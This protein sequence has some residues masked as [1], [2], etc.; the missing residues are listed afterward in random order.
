M[1]KR[2]IPVLFAFVFLLPIN[3]SAY[4]QEGS[5]STEIGYQSSTIATIP[6]GTPNTGDSKDFEKEL[7]ILGASWLLLILIIVLG[8]KGFDNKKELG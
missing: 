3:I 6:S 4:E 1:L 8:K 2:I 5:T 7:M